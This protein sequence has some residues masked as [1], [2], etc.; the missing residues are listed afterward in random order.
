MFLPQLHMELVKQNSCPP[1]CTL[2]QNQSKSGKLPQLKKTAT[3]SEN[4]RLHNDVC[5]VFHRQNRISTSCSFLLLS[6][7]HSLRFTTLQSMRFTLHSIQ[8]TT[9]TLHYNFQLA[10]STLYP[11]QSTSHIP[12]PT[13]HAPHCALSDCSPAPTSCMI[14]PKSLAHKKQHCTSSH[15]CAKHTTAEGTRLQRSRLSSFCVISM[16]PACGKD[17][18]HRNHC[19]LPQH[20]LD[21]KCALLHMVARSFV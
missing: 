4:R 5:I 19:V 14:L 3:F 21:E 8:S 2:M 17:D 16:A 10:H 9:R 7:P 11:P 20:F 1:N 6:T 18:M 12:Q 15:T 13:L